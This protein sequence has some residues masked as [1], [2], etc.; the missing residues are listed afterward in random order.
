MNS[1]NCLKIQLFHPAAEGEYQ[2]WISVK[3]CLSGDHLR[4]LVPPKSYWLDFAELAIVCPCRENRPLLSP[5][6]FD[7]FRH[8]F[9]VAV[10]IHFGEHSFGVPQRFGPR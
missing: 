1:L 10:A 7:F 4:W 5:G 6:G 3:H 2:D 9:A 8:Y